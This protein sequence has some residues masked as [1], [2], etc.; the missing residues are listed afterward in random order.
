MTTPG[1][2]TPGIWMTEAQFLQLLDEFHVT[3]V[4]KPDGGKIMLTVSDEGATETLT[5]SEYKNRAQEMLVELE[6]RK[7]EVEEN[8]FAV[9][10]AGELPT[11]ENRTL[12]VEYVKKNEQLTR[13]EESEKIRMLRSLDA[14]IVRQRMVVGA[15]N[16]LQIHFKELRPRFVTREVPPEPGVVRAD[17]VKVPWTKGIKS[18]ALFCLKEGNNP[19]NAGKS[20]LDLC[21][22]FLVTYTIA[23]EEDY[24]PEQ[25]CRNMQ[26]ILLLDRVG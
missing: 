25:L 23:G 8:R 11:G 3:H 24:T 19:A 12:R 15:M 6:D 2:R 14:A 26:Q 16:Y 1:P 18:A 9:P 7:R 5:V 22:D 4:F 10:L 20:A 17:G 21:R 13:E